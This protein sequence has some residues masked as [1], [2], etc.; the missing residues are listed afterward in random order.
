[1]K[2]PVLLV[3]ALEQ[4]NHQQSLNTFAD[5]ILYT[6]VGKV[7]AA[8]HLSH[9]LAGMTNPPLVINVGS[10][11]SHFF[12]AGEVV[13]I[14]QFVEHDM[15]ASAIGFELGQTP[16]EEDIALSCGLA[17]DG[18]PQATCYTG[19]SFVTEKHAHFE[20]QVIDMEAYALAKVCRHFKAPFLCL[21]FITD[22]ADGSAADDWQ[23]AL[24][25]SAQELEKALQHALLVL[26]TSDFLG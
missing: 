15:N 18:L 23:Q 11:G 4:E 13:C 20:L 5:E 6:G 16:F 14:T 12:N 3:L 24:V 17:I 10:A 21:K 8:L 2:R 19:D 1:M 9:K 22:G 26:H 7:N 25:R